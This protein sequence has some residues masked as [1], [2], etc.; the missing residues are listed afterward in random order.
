MTQA[1]AQ[2]ARAPRAR[3]ALGRSEEKRGRYRT[4]GQ[5]WSVVKVRSGAASITHRSAGVRA[6]KGAND[7]GATAAD[8]A[9]SAF[10][11][12]PGES[13]RSRRGDHGTYPGERR[14]SDRGNEIS[15][16]ATRCC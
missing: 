15:Q 9:E 7:F 6:G 14:R 8:I 4:A 13:T 5:K 2:S 12:R 16:S 11:G 1:K 3:P 10:F